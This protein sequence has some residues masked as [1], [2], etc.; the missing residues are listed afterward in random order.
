MLNIERAWMLWHWEI[1]WPATNEEDSVAT[2]APTEA[3]VV[4][5]TGSPTPAGLVALT[6]LVRYVS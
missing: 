3:T 4:A 5:A 1:P 6:S 2:L